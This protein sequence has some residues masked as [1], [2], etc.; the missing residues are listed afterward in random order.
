M[1]S[2]AVGFQCPECVREGS[3]T[4]R[5]ARTVGGG[6]VTNSPGIVTRTIVAI[7]CGFFVLQ[8]FAPAVTRALA[9]VSFAVA[10]GEWWRLVTVVLVHASILHV[11]FNMYALWLVGQQVEIWLGRSRF[12]GL[13]VISALAGSAL[14]YMFGQGYSV[15]ASGAI[16]GV[17]G[18]LA[19][20]SRRLGYDMRPAVALIAI[21]LVLSFTIPGID[22]HAH[23]GGLV[24]GT[25]LTIAFAYSPPRLRTVGA[26]GM[27]VVVVAVSLGMVVVHTQ[28]IKDDP[29]Q[30]PCV[31][32][33]HECLKQLDT[34]V[35]GL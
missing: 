7:T 27:S 33:V 18:A 26:V 4:V 17:F 10:A 14:S 16:F 2:A 19:V 5:Q 35:L 3:A 15:G 31:E 8:I 25:L 20:L 9:L 24:A 12:I 23:V 21:N 29:R 11:A 34:K 13:Y 28:T 6:L 32:H 1:T 22:W 30:E